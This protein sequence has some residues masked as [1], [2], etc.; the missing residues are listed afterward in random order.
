MVHVVSTSLIVFSAAITILETL[1]ALHSHSYSRG[2]GEGFDPGRVWFGIETA[3]VA[4]FTVE[5]IARALAWS[6]DWRRFLG[7]FGCEL[8]CSACK[9]LVNLTLYDNSVLCDH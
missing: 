4:M 3:L 5:Y 1:P 9:V 2:G 7:W 6:T 8:P